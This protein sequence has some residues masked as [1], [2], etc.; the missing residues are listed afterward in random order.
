MELVRL[1][2]NLYKEALYYTEEHP[3]LFFSLE[4]WLKS[5]KSELYEIIKCLDIRNTKR[6][7]LHFFDKYRIVPLREYQGEKTLVI[8]CGNS[9]LVDSGGYFFETVQE[10]VIYQKQHAHKGCYTICSDPCYNPSVVGFFSSN[11][12]KNIPDGAF[13]KIVIEGVKLEFNECLVS[14]LSRMLAD[15]GGILVNDI[16]VGFKRK[17]QLI[18]IGNLEP[19]FRGYK[20]YKLVY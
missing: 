3:Q 5:K 9:P 8:G 20:K 17:N 12:F 4:F 1:F 13:Y 18:F 7:M 10:K 19:Y 14:E 16:M 2:R 11:Y 15:K 6:N